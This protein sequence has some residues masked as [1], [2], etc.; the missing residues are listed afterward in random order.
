MQE[1]RGVSAES[2]ERRIVLGEEEVRCRRE[3]C[4]SY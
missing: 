3:D 1:L 2:V 4:A